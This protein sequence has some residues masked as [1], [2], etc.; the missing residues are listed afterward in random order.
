MAT[1]SRAAAKAR[2]DAA[3]YRTGLSTGTGEACCNN[4]QHVRPA[5][6]LMG[7]TSKDRLCALHNAG[8][9]THGCCRQ[10]ARPEVN[11]G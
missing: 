10:H 6:A 8:V 7:A 5:V 3:G 9:K 1:G 2:R 4:C 11:G